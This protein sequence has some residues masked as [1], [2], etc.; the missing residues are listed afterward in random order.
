MKIIKDYIEVLFLQVPI[1]EETKQIKED[2]LASAE[3]HY[4]GL[5][6]EGKSEKEAIG[7]VISEFGT[8][9]EI[10]TELNLEKETVE[11]AF[12]EEAFYEGKSS[13]TIEDALDH[14]REVRRLSLGVAAGFFFFISAFAF[15]PFMNG[16]YG[17][18]QAGMGGLLMFLFWALGFLFV[19]I[20]G[21]SLL[22]NIR[23]LKNTSI[24]GSVRE[25]AF[26]YA[27]G[28]R[29]SYLAGISAGVIAYALSLPS[30]IFFSEYIFYNDLGMSIFLGIFAMGTFLITYVFIIQREYRRIA[31]MKQKIQ[32]KQRRTKF[33]R[34]GQKSF[35][36]EDTFWI[37]VTICYFIISFLFAS[38]LYSWLIFLIGYVVQSFLK[39]QLKN[40]FWV[41][42]TIVYFIFSF[43]FSSWLYS[44]LIFLIGFAVQS[45][46]RNKERLQEYN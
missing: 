20:N 24:P 30:G 21:Y 46:F 12:E 10:L 8:I 29:R 27:E 22:K 41:I 2:L 28:Y 33:N 15:I 32:T 44:W 9:D 40:S 16:Y 3:D 35:H 11:D 42:V 34:N 17:G 31:K 4:Y 19:T 37:I 7:I 5:M 13:L 18:I 1:T 25:E 23:S 39:N 45:F 6:E 26:E 43:M 36:Y 38:W 14:W